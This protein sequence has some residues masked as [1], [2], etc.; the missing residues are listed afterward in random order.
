MNIYPIIGHRKPINLTQDVVNLS[1][2]FLPFM[3]VGYE[4][5]KAH[6]TICD[7]FDYLKNHKNEFDVIITDSTDPE[8][9][10]YCP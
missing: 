7:G 10:K 8:G 4:S 1:K 9:F 2:E 3:A 6:V 5:D